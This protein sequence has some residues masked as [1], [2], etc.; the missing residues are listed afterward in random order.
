MLLFFFIIL[1]QMGSLA[2]SKSVQCLEKNST[3]R[4][5]TEKF[6][7]IYLNQNGKYYYVLLIFFIKTIKDFFSI[8]QCT[9]CLFLWYSMTTQTQKS[10]LECR[11]ILWDNPI[12][13][14]F[15][16]VWQTWHHMDMGSSCF[17][18]CFHN[19]HK[20]KLSIKLWQACQR[21]FI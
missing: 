4:L 12:T 15:V 14:Q 8:I 7:C 17:D 11:E 16:V 1:A 21:G 19:R 6:V 9:T 13:R 20:F 3:S 2:L 10:E 18:D 5:V